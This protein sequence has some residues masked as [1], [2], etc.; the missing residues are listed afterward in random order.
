MPLEMKNW[1]EEVVGKICWRLPNPLKIKQAMLVGLSLGAAITVDF[2]LT[3]SERVE[4]LVLVCPG[5][6][7]FPF[8]DPANELRPVVEAVE[9]NRIDRATERWLTNPS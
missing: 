1:N 8:S 3:H 6:G 9:G 4:G 7:R 5:L 2:V